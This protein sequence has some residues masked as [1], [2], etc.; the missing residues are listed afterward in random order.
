MTTRHGWSCHES[1][2]RFKDASG[3]QY[4][5]ST[6]CK[7]H[8]SRSRYEGHHYE[9]W[10]A[11]SWRLPEAVRQS[12]LCQQ[13]P[14]I[15]PSLRTH[16][17]LGVALSATRSQR[18][19][20]TVVSCT[21]SPIDKG[22]PSAFGRASLPNTAPLPSALVLSN[23]HITAMSSF[24]PRTIPSLTHGSSSFPTARATAQKLGARQ[25][26]F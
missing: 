7:V 26:H 8:C 25:A 19:S 20:F 4:S 10:Q 3:L 11:V 18:Q 5:V 15:V 17:S 24:R 12:Q 21:T 6:G 2:L 14:A 22:L 9:A 13:Q 1:F 23:C 16:S